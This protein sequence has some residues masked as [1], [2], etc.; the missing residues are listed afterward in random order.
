MRRMNRVTNFTGPA[1]EQTS[2]GNKD[3]GDPAVA[4]QHYSHMLILYGPSEIK[5]SRARLVGA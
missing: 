5:V 2:R 4:R 3:R 1:C